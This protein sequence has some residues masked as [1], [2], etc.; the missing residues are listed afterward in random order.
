LGRDSDKASYPEPLESD[1]RSFFATAG[2]TAPLTFSYGLDGI[3]ILSLSGIIADSVHRAG[4][5]FHLGHTSPSSTLPRVVKWLDEWEQL[6]EHAKTTAYTTT[7]ALNDAIWRTMITDRECLLNR[8]YC[9]VRQSYM[10]Q[11]QDVTTRCS[12]REAREEASQR[13]YDAKET[14]DAHDYLTSVNTLAVGRR[15]FITWKV[16]IGLG[17]KIIQAEDVISVVIGCKVP[18]ILRIDKKGSYPLVGQAY[19]HG[20]MDGKVLQME[21]RIVD[22]DL[23]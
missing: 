10:Q 12:T 23:Y 17:P 11:V 15:P 2:L 20:M 6:T 3:P 8:G 16:Y 5:V 18:K 7:V 22:I 13:V 14:V 1:F 9:R 4:S 19:V 21:H